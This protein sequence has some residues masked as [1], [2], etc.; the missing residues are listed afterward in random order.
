MIPLILSTLLG[1]LIIDVNLKH[2]SRFHP[3]LTIFLAPGLGLGCSALLVFLALVI[4]GAYS[5]PVVLSLHALTI[6]LLFIVSARE[7]RL[8]NSPFLKHLWPREQLHIVDVLFLLIFPGLL[9]II[10]SHAAAHPYGEW[11]AWTVWNLKTKFLLEGGGRWKDIF[12]LAPRTRPEAPL[13]LPCALTWLHGHAPGYRPAYPFAAGIVFTALVSGMLYAGIR[14]LTSGVLPA[15][16]GWLALSTL[17]YFLHF[18]TAQSA[19]IVL[20]YYFL[21]GL[22]TLFLALRHGHAGMGLI[23]GCCCGLMSFS[24]GEG[25]ALSAALTL[26]VAA[27]AVF[28]KTRVP[29]RSETVCAFGFGTLLT[30]LAVMILKFF[31]IPSGGGLT[32]LLA[33]SGSAPHWSGLIHLLR[34]SATLA[35]QPQLRGLWFLMLGMLIV[36]RRAWQA[37]EKRIGAILFA[38][39]GLTLTA[40]YLWTAGED[41]HWRMYKALGRVTTTLLPGMLFFNFFCLWHKE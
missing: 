22:V 38:G 30:G 10:A 31:F 19:D 25:L 23:S 2:P 8:Q 3:L 9:F 12:M 27:H 36:N 21:A 5:L 28:S 6:L 17:P 1:W 29:R 41:Q 4:R 16:L 15:L 35:R 26:S 24:K 18:G 39:L 40:V 11:D 34:D 32:A 33:D 37:D 13:L 20:S 14:Q 7:R